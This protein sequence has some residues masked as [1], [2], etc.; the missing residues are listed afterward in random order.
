MLPKHP[1]SQ[2]GRA[3]RLNAP[4]LTCHLAGQR[5]MAAFARFQALAEKAGFNPDQPRVPAGNPDGSQWAG[6]DGA[7]GSRRHRRQWRAFA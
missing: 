1:S 2:P 6:S 4:A 7:A 3:T 5:M